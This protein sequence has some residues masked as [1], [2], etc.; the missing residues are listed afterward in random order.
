[1]AARF[2]VWHA[3][4]TLEERLGAGFAA[5][6]PRL[7]AAL[8]L[9]LSG[10][11]CSAEWQKFSPDTETLEAFV[12]RAVDHIRDAGRV[13]FTDSGSALADFDQALGVQLGRISCAACCEVGSLPA[14]KICR[15]GEYTDLETLDRGGL[16]LKELRDLFAQCRTLASAWH[17]MPWPKDPVLDVV[18]QWED[19][20]SGFGEYFADGVTRRDEQSIT[21]ELRLNHL[22]FDVSS[23]LAL[24]YVLLH[25]LVA[26]G[27]TPPQHGSPLPESQFDEGWMDYVV[28]LLIEALDRKDQGLVLSGSG[29]G[30]LR[31]RLDAAKRYHLERH[32]VLGRQADRITRSR[33][34]GRKLACL[35]LD[36]FRRLSATPEA[37][38]VKFSLEL[39]RAP[40]DWRE[41]NWFVNA[42][43]LMLPPEGVLTPWE[44]FDGQHL[45]VEYLRHRDLGKFMND[46]RRNVTSGA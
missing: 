44:Y 4:L 31:R 32:N 1:M 14:D 45:V 40:I 34:Y 46:V 42:L 20:V 15:G 19:P 24:F 10:Q 37:D 29:I 18:V 41:K 39:N 33:A 25:E 27:F 7:L 2:V 23:Y 30:H 16:C 9:F 8:E 11:T 28:S 3:L 21:I 38:F 12:G 26:H 13:H 43:A 17:K 5:A 36:L 22:R 6:T 35:T